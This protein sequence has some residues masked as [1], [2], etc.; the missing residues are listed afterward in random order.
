[1]IGTSARHGI[2][3]T[4]ANFTQRATI[5]RAFF[6][7]NSP[8]S[9]SPESFLP[10]ALQKV[11]FPETSDAYRDSAFR[12]PPPAPRQTA[13]CRPCNIS[14]PDGNRTRH[15]SGHSSQAGADNAFPARGNGDLPPIGGCVTPA[16]WRGS[17]RPQTAAEPPDVV[18]RMAGCFPGHFP[19]AARA[20]TCPHLVA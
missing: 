12:D 19:G 15:R 1:M 14:S 13:A 3:R 16:P 5:S 20:A 4:F 8:V 9:P 11:P 17:H 18:A 7:K 6:Q 10:V 2:G